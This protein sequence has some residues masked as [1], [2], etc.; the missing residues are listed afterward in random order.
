MDEI[1]LLTKESF[2]KAINSFVNTLSGIRTGRANPNILD[3]V[4]VDYY[5]E[6]TPLNQI[7]LIS[8]PEPQL[9]QIKPYDAGDIRSIM[10]AL[11]DSD[12][13]LNPVSDAAVIRIAIPPLTEERRRDFVKNAKK[14]AED[15]KIAIRNIRR[16]HLG[17]VDKDEYSEDLIK[18]IEVE[19]QKVTDE[20]I[21]KIDDLLKKKET[22]IMTI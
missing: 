5:G 2:D 20:A 22:E 18:R 19:I 4:M 9:L 10:A 8:A 13:G 6:K 15:S 21:R 17:L 7:S 12:L 16:D 11:N 3:R 1:I 14:F